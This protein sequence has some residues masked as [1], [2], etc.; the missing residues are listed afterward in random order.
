[1][2]LATSSHMVHSM[3]PI[4][5]DSLQHFSRYSVNNACY[6]RF[7][8][9]NRFWFIHINKWFHIQ[10]CWNHKSATPVSL[11]FGN[12]NA[13]IITLWRAPSTVT[14]TPSAFLKKYS[15]SVPPAHKPHQTVHFSGCIGS[16]WIDWSH[17]N[18]K[19]VTFNV[20]E[21]PYWKK[22]LLLDHPL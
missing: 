13:F 10:S 11:I 14:H 2:L 4:F 15:P 9:I 20:P 18:I 7:Q 1:M 19:I 21:N 12:K 22:Y 8:C 17:M 16:S 5:E 6:V 3:G